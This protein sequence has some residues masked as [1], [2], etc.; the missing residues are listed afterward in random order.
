MDVH[1]LIIGTP[2]VDP[3]GHGYVR[4]L[5]CPSEMY[6]DIDFHKRGWSAQNYFRL[7]GTVYSSPGQ[8]AYKIEGKW[9]ESVTLVNAKTGEREVVWTKN[10]YPENWEY[11]YGMSKFALQLNNLPEG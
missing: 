8:V 9:N 10:P 5:A 7:D 1:N 4:N 3:G 11:M 2:Y 6:V